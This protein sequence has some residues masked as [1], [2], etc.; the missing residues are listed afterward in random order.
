MTSLFTVA[1]A[2]HQLRLMGI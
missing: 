1:Q 2:G